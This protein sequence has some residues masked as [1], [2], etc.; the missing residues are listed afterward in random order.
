[1]PMENSCS[2]MKDDFDITN[3]PSN[4]AY[5]NLNKYLDFIELLAITSIDKSCTLSMIVDIMEENDGFENQDYREEGFDQ[6]DDSLS[7]EALVINNSP[8]IAE[9]KS[10]LIKVIEY[11]N[12][13]FDDYWP[14][15]YDK[16]TNKISVLTDHN[17]YKL[18][19]CLLLSSVLFI[20][21]LSNRK[22]FTDIHEVI[23]Y[24]V[25]KK[26]FPEDAGWSVK[27]FGANQT[28]GSYYAGNLKDKFELLA[29]DLSTALNPMATFPSSSGDGGIDAVVFRKFIKDD[30]GLLPFCTVQSTCM[31]DK[32]ELKARETSYAR[33][34]DKIILKTS[35]T[36]FLI[37][38]RDMITT[39]NNTK[40]Q[41]D[42]NALSVI[43]DRFRILPLINTSDIPLNTNIT[44]MI[45]DLENLNNNYAF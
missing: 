9:F 3:L 29:K 36:N 28:F 2:W 30:R 4:R 37:S 38:P 10:H 40:F 44:T 20:M 19:V 43:I 31:D 18:Y 7:Y 6:L 8:S 32:L 16:E 39:V 42:D 35:L 24:E 27:S 1:M 15:E 34:N 23:G 13:K 45:G 22:F 5:K 41:I 25:I 21:K 14:F 17:F 11:R 33:I 12:E 26:I